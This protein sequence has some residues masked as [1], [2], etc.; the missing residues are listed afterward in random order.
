MFLNRGDCSHFSCWKYTIFLSHETI[1]TDML[2]NQCYRM[3][4]R[5]NPQAILHAFFIPLL[6]STNMPCI[7]SRVMEFSATLGK[8]SDI[9]TSSTTSTCAKMANIIHFPACHAKYLPGI[10]L[11]SWKNTRVAKIMTMFQGLKNTDASTGEWGLDIQL[12][13]HPAQLMGMLTTI[14]QHEV[15]GHG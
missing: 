12:S 11:F 5:W 6:M 9:L 7:Q 14:I 8:T 3:Y 13:K 2:R 10:H 15:Q 1:P 4:I